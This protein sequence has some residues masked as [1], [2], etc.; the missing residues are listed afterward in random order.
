MPHLSKKKLSR[1]LE[2]S[3]E[4]RFFRLIVEESAKNRSVILKNLITPT[5][6][7]MILK[8]LSLIVLVS[9]GHSLYRIMKLTGMSPSTIERY[10]LLISQGKFKETVAWVK[11]THFESKLLRNLLK[12]MVIPFEARR[13]SLHRA[14]TDQ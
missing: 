8:R 6:K 1:S 14:L 2:S 5:E 4:S 3:A 10:K 13:Q 11:K 7:Q 9:K 12:L